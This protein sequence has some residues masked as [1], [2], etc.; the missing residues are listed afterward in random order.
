M[1]TILAFIVA[2]IVIVA[3]HEF[4]HYL[5]MRAFGVRV[6]TFSIGFGPRLFAWRDKHGTDFT[7]ASIPLGGYVKPLDRRDCDVTPE[8]AGEE[9]SGKPAW[10]RVITYAA[11]PLANLV[12]AVFLYWLMM[13]GGE[14]GRIPYLG[15][16]APDTAAAQAGLRAGDEI[17]AVGDQSTQNW[18]QVVTAF[19]EYAG[20]RDSVTLRVRSADGAERDV[21]LPLANWADNQETHPLDALGL[22]PKP[23]A[24][25]IGEVLEGSAAEAA[26]LQ[27]GDLVVA[28]D[29]EPVDSWRDWVDIVR[30]NP[31]TTLAH[32]VQRDGAELVLTLTPMAVEQD[33]Q[34]I[35]Q[36]GV[37]PAE[38]IADIREI[39]Y[40]PLAALAEAVQ[41][42]GSLVEM[43]VKSIGRLVT[44]E[45]SV[46]TL[47]GPL[48][49]AGAAGDA[50]A[51]GLVAFAGMLAF[52]SV[53]L[54][55]IN[56]LPVP[57]LD[58]GW[59]VFGLVEMV[60]RRPLPER[61]LMA[62]QSVGLTLVLALM[63]LAIFNDL[64]RYF[65]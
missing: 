25:R 33:G 34:K 60:I 27:P 16:V 7:I 8:Q 53:S 40:G 22:A 30:A 10:Q 55:V 39:H 3:I 65:A 9:F 36:A 15:N 52:L 31:Q 28:V 1:T 41:R 63:A 32:S 21:Q 46:K 57:M 35:G 50:A 20:V 51:L 6:L 43:M 62:A 59:I 11:G 56:L 2:I 45:M 14:S 44:G 37:Y 47:G 13:L 12:L 29:G 38:N 19:L 18:P 17:V 5:A 64:V 58:G 61:F 24:P 54:G 26:G 23:L 48:T 4:G 42:V 49:I